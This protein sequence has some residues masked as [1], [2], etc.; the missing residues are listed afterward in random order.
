MKSS[1]PALLLALALTSGCSLLHF[2]SKKS[3]PKPLEPAAEVQV[4]FHDRWVD[5]R[6][7]ELLTAGSATTEDQARAMAEAEFAKQYTFVKVPEKGQR[8]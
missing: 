7:H 8:H 6:I 2:M 4:E 5:K 1:V 3:G